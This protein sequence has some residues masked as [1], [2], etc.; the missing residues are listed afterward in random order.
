M[1]DG[2]ALESYKKLVADN[3]INAVDK[4]NANCE[5]LVRLI[6]TVLGDLPYPGNKNCQYMHR[7]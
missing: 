3:Y 7:Y 2:N 6:P 1:F 4:T 5:E